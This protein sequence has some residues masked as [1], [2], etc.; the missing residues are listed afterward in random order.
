M[1]W[2]HDYGTWYKNNQQLQ[3]SDQYDLGIQETTYVTVICLHL[4]IVFRTNHLTNSKTSPKLSSHWHFRKHLGWIFDQATG[5]ML[6][7]AL[8][9]SLN[10][11]RNKPYLPTQTTQRFKQK[12]IRSCVW[13]RAS[14]KPKIWWWFIC[15]YIYIY[16]LSTKGLILVVWD[17]PICLQ[18]WG[19]KN[20]RKVY[21]L[22]H[23]LFWGYQDSLQSPTQHQAAR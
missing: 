17:N 21:V 15:K 12:V 10:R 4:V 9:S 19:V 20:I 1:S 7:G 23:W 16:I 3:G 18:K 8:T 13:K 6:L 14:L 11:S 5:K 2:P 22:C